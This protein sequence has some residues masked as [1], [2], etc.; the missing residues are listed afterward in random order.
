M[1]KS[2]IDYT[3]YLVTDRRLMSCKTIEESVSLAID[4]G[5]SVVQL[6]EKD[7]SSREFYEL[8]VRVKKITDPRKVP[9]I[10]NDRIDIALA[11][12]ADGVH[13]G[14]SD[15]PCHEARKIL[16]ADK[17]IGVSAALPEEAAQAQADGADYLGVGAVFSTQ[18]KTNTRP[19]T[20]GIIRQI[21]SAVTIP[22]VV[23]GG[24]NSENIKELYGLGVNGAAVVSSVVAQP[25]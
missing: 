15:I 12:N 22:F 20:P 17:I 13:L 25:D 24:I 2:K 5:A 19:V 3:L 21:R 14:Q 8:A 16:G 10:I 18:T 6:R 23:I 11:A 1:D 7:C 4:G 9:L